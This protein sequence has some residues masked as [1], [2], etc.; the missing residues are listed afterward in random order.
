VEEA[1]LR[2]V[3]LRPAEEGEARDG[4]P[5]SLGVARAMAAGLD[6]HP[7]VT[8][9][10]GENGAGKSTLVEAMAVAAGCNPEGGSDQLRFSSRASESA[11]G[12]HTTL[13]RG[14][15]RPRTAFFLRAEAMFNVST[16]IEALPG[17]RAENLAPYGGVSLHEQSHGESFLAVV[18]NRF[19]DRG[20]Y[21]LD[22]P[23]A[24]LSTQNQLTLLARMHDLV[25]A[26]SQFIVATHSP[27]LLA[28][29]GALILLCHEEGVEAVAYDDAEPVTLT[30]AFL[31]DPE[32]FIR[33]LTR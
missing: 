8:F 13:V 1:F 30:R 9:L 14:V 5:W 25:R 12:A 22:E 7:R 18:L 20:L 28:F 4:Y 29:P 32:Q 3:R 27:I 26:G 33:A 21:F 6:L 15:K 23:E 16:Q 17:S 31:G 24:A 2:G 19:G 10:I 11:L